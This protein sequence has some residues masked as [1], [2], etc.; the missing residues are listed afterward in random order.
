MIT[1]ESDI[2]A[3]VSKKSG[4]TFPRKGTAAPANP[5]LQSLFAVCGT[6]PTTLVAYDCKESSA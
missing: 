1:P 3:T 4:I 2:P 5:V 6:A